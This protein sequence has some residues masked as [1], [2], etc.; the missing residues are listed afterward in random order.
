MRWQEIKNS[1]ETE[2]SNG[3]IQIQTHTN[4]RKQCMQQPAL[5]VSH[6]S[7]TP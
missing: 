7:Y 6:I 2:L 4:L 1:T 3:E 5:I